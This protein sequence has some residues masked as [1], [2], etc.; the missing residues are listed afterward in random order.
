M[1]SYLAVEGTV[2][3][4]R[5]GYI[6]AVFSHGNSDKMEACS[7]NGTWRFDNY[8]PETTY[9]RQLKVQWHLLVMVCFSLP[10]WEYSLLPWRMTYC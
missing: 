8:S 4:V 6:R 1:D 9:K 7:G 3:E 10:L 2:L 5:R